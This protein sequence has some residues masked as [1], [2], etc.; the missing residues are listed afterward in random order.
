MP[1][2]FYGIGD[3]CH[4]THFYVNFTDVLHEYDSWRPDAMIE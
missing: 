3:Y 1:A 2:C 4:R